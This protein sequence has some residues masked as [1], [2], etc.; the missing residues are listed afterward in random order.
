MV[1]FRPKD[2]AKLYETIF[3]SQQKYRL[4]KHNPLVMLNYITLDLNKNGFKVVDISK[5]INEMCYVRCDFSAYSFFYKGK[6]I[7][8]NE[9]GYWCIL[10]ERLHTCKNL[11]DILKII[12]EEVN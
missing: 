1:Y 10:N 9:Y 11:E 7:S 5:E 8:Q 12:D 3:L 4:E 2:K 6:R